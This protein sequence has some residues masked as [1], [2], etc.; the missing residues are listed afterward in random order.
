[1]HPRDAVLQAPH[2]LVDERD[3]VLQHVGDR[4]VDRV[5]R[6]LADRPLDDLPVAHLLVLGVLALRE[7]DDLRQDLD[8]LVDRRAAAIDDVGDLFQIFTKT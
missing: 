3:Q 1:M 7:R 2:P 5:A 4:G 6:A 8:F